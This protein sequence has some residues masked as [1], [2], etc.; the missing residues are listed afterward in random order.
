[1][2]S[3]DI[4]YLKSMVGGHF[5]YLYM[6]ED[7]WSRKIIGWAVHEEKS[8]TYASELISKTAH[9]LGLVGTNWA[10]HSDNGGRMKGSTTLA[11]LQRLGIVGSFSRPR[12]CDD[13]PYSESLFR[14][15]KYRPEYPSRPF[16]SSSEAEAWVPQF[17]L[18]VFGGPC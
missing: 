17:V 16:A 3:W 2:A 8:M 14:T 1:M 7:I 9:R 5:F 6:I 4:T 10:L 12:I 11:T 13:N 18:C 15:L